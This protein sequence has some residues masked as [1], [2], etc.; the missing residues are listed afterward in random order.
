[1]LVPTLVFS[2]FAALLVHLLVRRHPATDP[3]LTATVLGL[4]LLLPLLDLLPKVAVE[5]PDARLTS[6]PSF[7]WLL[8]VLWLSGFLVVAA[9]WLGDRL[10]L[11]RWAREAAPAPAMPVF[12]ETLREL[13]LTRP[14]ALR[15]HPALSSPVVAGLRRPC[16]YLPSDAPTWAS[17]TLRMALLHELTHLQRRDLW[18]A[19]LARLVCLV[20]WFNPAV[21]WLRR[22]FL[23]Q[24]EFSCDARLV[25]RGTDP[26]AYAHALCD[27]A[28]SAAAP[29]GSLAMAGH[30]PLRQR[31]LFLSRQPGRRPFLLLFLL[32]LTAASAVA[33]SVVRIAPPAPASRIFPPSPASEESELRF[34]ADPF[35]AD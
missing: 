7:P 4:I 33:L 8:P 6:A 11:R 19:S 14:V 28:R 13:G 26:R 10:A 29:S 22:T 35:P 25:A 23:S 27:L 18:M 15:L 5:L 17:E 2:L 24:C 20:H 32:L 9:R 1:M 16:I 21:W 34:T 12:Q 31:I 3:R 30:A